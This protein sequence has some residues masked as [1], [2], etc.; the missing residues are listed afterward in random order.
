MQRAA[1]V[2]VFLSLVVLSRETYAIDVLSVVLQ[3]MMDEKIRDDPEIKKLLAGELKAE[4]EVADKTIASVQAAI[5]RYK[6]SNP[7]ESITVDLSEYEGTL[8]SAR[9]WNLDR[10][11]LKKQRNAL[12]SERESLEAEKEKLANEKDDVEARERFYSGGFFSTIAALFIAVLGHV[13]RF[14]VSRLDRQLKALEVEEK[15]L[16]LEIRRLQASGE[17]SGDPTAESNAPAEES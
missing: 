15:R 8:E 7:P 17:A 14:P 6:A 2:F 11:S 13:M 5:D 9:I 16:E 3:K 10:M 1:S 4:P 12:E